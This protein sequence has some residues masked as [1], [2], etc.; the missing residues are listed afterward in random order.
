MFHLLRCIFSVSSFEFFSF[1]SL[2]SRLRISSLEV[3]AAVKFLALI[4]LISARLV[5]R[6]HSGQVLPVLSHWSIQLWP[7]RCPQG[8]EE[9]AWGPGDE[10][11]PFEQTTSYEPVIIFLTLT[12]S[13]FEI[14]NNANLIIQLGRFS[15]LFAK[16]IS[17]IVFEFSRRTYLKIF[18]ISLENS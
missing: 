2:I 18:E 6:L 1:N 7:K 10:Y 9:I 11:F 12:L 4:N 8:K 14:S 3:S 5:G 13:G 17:I 15:G 16:I